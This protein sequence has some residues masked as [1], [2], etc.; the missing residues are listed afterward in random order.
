MVVVD[1]L[2]GREPRTIPLINT[3]YSLVT[4]NRA[5]SV[6]G[7]YRYS[8]VQVRLLTTSAGVS[9]VDADQTLEARYAESWYQNMT[10]DVFR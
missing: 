4:P 8:Q 6:S 3:C 10:A 9:P 5:I 2:N 7:V 1:R